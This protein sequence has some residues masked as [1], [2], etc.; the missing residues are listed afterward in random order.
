MPQVEHIKILA[1]ANPDRIGNASLVKRAIDDLVRVVEMTPLGE[2]MVFDVP[3]EIEKLNRIPFEDEGGITTQRGSFAIENK[4]EP[5]IMGFTTLSTSHV[6]IHT[7]PLREEL[8]I[9]I[10]SCR[11]Y[12]SEDVINF[13]V[14]VFHITRKKVTDLTE[15]C[16]W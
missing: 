7:W 11:K 13:L 14:E 12:N 9:D 5:V 16:D 10:Y 15:A 2:S 4:L 8:K 1:K 6:A 3:L